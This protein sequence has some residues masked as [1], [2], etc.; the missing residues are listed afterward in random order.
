MINAVILVFPATESLVQNGGS[1]RRSKTSSEKYLAAGGKV[2]GGVSNG[3]LGALLFAI[4]ESIGCFA[5]DANMAFCCWQE[6][7]RSSK[8]AHGETRTVYCFILV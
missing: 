1:C 4:N 6:S 3:R 2:S 7:I 5:G 8:G